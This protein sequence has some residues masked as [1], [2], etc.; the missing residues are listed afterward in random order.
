MLHIDKKK[1]QFQ[2]PLSIKEGTKK[3]NYWN[4]KKEGTYKNSSV[5]NFRNEFGNTK[6]TRSRTNNGPCNGERREN[7]FYGEIK[8]VNKILTIFATDILVLIIREF[9][10]LLYQ[11]ICSFR[12]GLSRG[13]RRES[14]WVKDSVLSLTQQL[15]FWGLTKH[16]PN[17]PWPA[18][19]YGMKGIWMRYKYNYKYQLVKFGSVEFFI[20]PT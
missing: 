13:E 14:V 1:S 8:N 6:T 9:L 5:G 11:L 17:P 15:N 2:I 16:H 7:Q 20:L 3:K 4:N 18:G 10:H 12:H 19:P